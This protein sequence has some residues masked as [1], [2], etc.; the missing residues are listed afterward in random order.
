MKHGRF[1]RTLCLLYFIR[2]LCLLAG[3]PGKIQFL[4]GT[5][6]MVTGNT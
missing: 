1:P 3:Q 4:V 2:L 5:V 6:S